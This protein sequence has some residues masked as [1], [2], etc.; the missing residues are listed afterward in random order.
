MLRIE[1]RWLFVLVC[2]H[3][4][5]RACYCLLLGVYFVTFGYV[6]DRLLV[7]FVYCVSGCCASA[8]LLLI[9]FGVCMLIVSGL[10]LVCLCL[11]L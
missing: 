10:L 4:C 3:F 2:L 5:C 7:M 6:G 8:E 11:G 9:Y 1:D